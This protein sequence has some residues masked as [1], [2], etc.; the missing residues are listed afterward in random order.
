ML[1]KTK[2]NSPIIG[3]ASELRVRSELLLHGFKPASGDYDDG[4]DIILID[5]G[6]KI[7][8]KSSLKPIYSKKNY[9]WRYTF[10][11]RMAQFRKGNS[12]NYKKETTRRKYNVD[13]FIFWCIEHNIFYI[14]PEDKIGE[15]I[16]F[17]ISSKGRK[18]GSKYDE[19]KNN[20]NLLNR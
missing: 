7:Q 14:I 13:F 10:A 17:C 15:K 11:I 9:S 8:V 19:F 1:N 20:W 4:V 16:S 5:N 3:I 6:I 18:F 12:G 2:I